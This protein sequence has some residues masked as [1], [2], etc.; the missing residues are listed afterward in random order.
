MISDLVVPRL[1]E[2]H[3]RREG[4]FNKYL[5]DVEPGAALAAHVERR[6]RLL[7]MRA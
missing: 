4:E 2:E 5:Q 1:P 6:R 7:D 3:R